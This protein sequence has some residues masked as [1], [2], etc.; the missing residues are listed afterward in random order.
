MLPFVAFH[1]KLGENLLEYADNEKD[2]GVDITSNFS[3]NGHCDKII[4]RA[5]QKLGMLRRTCNFV[6]DVKR[7]RILYLTLVRS[8]FEHCSQIWHPNNSTLMGKFENVQKKCLK[9]VLCEEEMSYNN[10]DVYIRKCKQVN[11]L[12]MSKRFV[13][14][15]ITLFHKIVYNL[16][17]VKLPDYISLFDG[18]TRLRSCHLDRLS[19]VSSVLPRGKNCKILKKSLFYRGHLLWNELPLEIREIRCQTTFKFRVKQ[20]LWTLASSEFSNTEL[21]ISLS[22]GIT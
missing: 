3:Y 11:V 19:Y 22:D 21:D 1:Y 7:R 20:H 10:K 14:N 8:Q 2:L 17:P 4:S 12:P 16:I 15:D 18:V 5:N 6:N 13:L 9:W